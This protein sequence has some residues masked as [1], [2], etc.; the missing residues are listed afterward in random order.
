MRFTLKYRVSWGRV[1]RSFRS[2]KSMSQYIRRHG[3]TDYQKFVD[4]EQF[5]FFNDTIVKRRDL[6]IL[7]KQFGFNT[8]VLKSLNLHS[9]IVA[10]PESE[11]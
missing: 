2:I 11:V 8:A 4:G 3:L 6:E 5:V 10:K 9:A 7:L 1:S